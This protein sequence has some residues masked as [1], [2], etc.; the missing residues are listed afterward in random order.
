[1]LALGFV[2]GVPLLWGAPPPRTAQQLLSPALVHLW[3]YT[4]VLGCLVALLGVTWT[5]WG[6]LGRWFSRFCPTDA[7]GLLIEQLGVLAVGVGA[8]IYGVGIVVA[9]APGSGLPAGI[10]LGFGAAC[11]WRWGQIQRL[12]RVAATIE[13]IDPAP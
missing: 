8:V 13:P 10:V 5:W 9:A 7:T 3:G 2:S 6:W 4:L 11:F 12:V 1:M